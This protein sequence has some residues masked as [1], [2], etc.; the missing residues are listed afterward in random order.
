[1]D[2]ALDETEMTMTFS[3]TQENDCISKKRQAILQFT[4]KTKTTTFSLDVPEVVI[5]RAKEVDLHINDT[6]LSGRHA[7][8]LV[9]HNFYYIEDLCSRNGT[10]VNGEPIS[11][12]RLAHQDVIRLGQISLRFIQ[13]DSIDENY[14]NKLNLQT[15][16]SLALAVEA[17]D[18]YTKG[19]SERVGEI[20]EHLATMM[21]LSAA[22]IERVRIAG[23][24][25]D[26][27]KIGVSET[28][29][30]KKTKLDTAEFESIKQHPVE[31]LNILRPLNFL[32][33]IIP[34]VYHHHERYDG[35]GYPD[36]LAGEDI[37]YWARIVQVADTYD[38][39]TSDRP[40]RAAYSK[41]QA[42]TEISRCA[43]TQLDPNVTH[44][45]LKILQNDL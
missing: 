43:G 16:Q 38:A 44:T 32:N 11:F 25:H 19:H 37:P 21:G 41:S 5:G 10:T 3:D 4:N 8:I 18:P 23:I 22:D 27:G 39:M 42:I 29:L 12:I 36:G 28:L 35:T 40:Y 14:I 20:S 6:Y 9:V 1:M 2:N 33:D 7:R 31:G 13:S 26:I 17:K 15:I 34:A 45:M 30:L 24:L